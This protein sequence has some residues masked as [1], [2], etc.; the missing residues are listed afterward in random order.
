MHVSSPF[1]GLNCRGGSLSV[2][3]FAVRGG[4]SSSTSLSAVDQKTID[5]SEVKALTSPKLAVRNFG[6]IEYQDTRSDQSTENLFRVLFVLGGPGAGKG[7]QSALMEEQYP[8]VHLSVGDLLRAEQGKED[9]P[10]REL[11]QQTLV[12]GKI[13][14]VE[15]SLSLLQNAMKEKSDEMGKEIIFLVDGFPRNFDNLSGWSR[16]MSDVATLWGVL[17]YQCP[18]KVLE[19]RILERAKSSG[20]ADDNLQSVKKR[21]K[22]FEGDT[23]PVIDTLREASESDGANWAVIDIRGDQPLEDVWSLTQ[24]VLNDLILHDVVSANV[25]LLKA[26]ESGDVKTYESLTDEEWFSGG[27]DAMEVM[28]KQEGDTAD[29]S[30]DNVKN[31]KFEVMSGTRVALSYDRILQGEKMTEKRIWSHKGKL[32]WRNIHFSRIPCP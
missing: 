11:I 2:P 18:L 7:T 29:S 22:T 9:S 5:P 17:C 26:V 23:V 6:G 24:G 28:K 3:S 21:F 27:K 15:I 20:R 32:G 12:A 30:L 4:S 16:Y 14:P 1:A 19:D 31:A 10:H 8:T 13:V 25:A